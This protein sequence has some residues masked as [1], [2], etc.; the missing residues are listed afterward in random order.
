MVIAARRRHNHNQ[1]GHRI[2]EMDAPLHRLKRPHRPAA[3]RAQTGDTEPLGHHLVLGAHHVADCIA[4]KIR[5]QPILRRGR[6]A[7]TDRISPDDEIFIG[8]KR[9]AGA[10]MRIIGMPATAGAGHQQNGVALVR[11]QRAPGDIP[12]LHGSDLTAIFKGEPAGIIDRLGLS[13]RRHRCHHQRGRQHPSQPF[14]AKRCHACFLPIP[15]VAST[16]AG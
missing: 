8:V 2:R 14:H 10:D 4:G 7:T 5:P 12:N 16:S 6:G 1:P 11:I 13:L 9:L 3:D 15:V